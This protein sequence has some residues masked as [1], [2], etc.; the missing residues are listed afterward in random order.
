[1]TGKVSQGATLSYGDGG[2]PETF[3][4]VPGTP[5]LQAPGFEVTSIDM[6]STDSV[7]GAFEPGKPKIQ[8]ISGNVNFDPDNTAHMAM[9]TKLKA[10][11]KGNW[12]ITIP[13]TSPDTTC[14]FEA[15]MTTWGPP[16]IADD[17]KITLSWG[18]QP[19][20]DATWA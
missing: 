2:S 9:L 17:D 13:D 16:A 7:L 18:L 4:V 20:Q 15:F 11:T 3:T 8:P 5:D 10:R 12:R 14:T 1:M 6:S 19:T